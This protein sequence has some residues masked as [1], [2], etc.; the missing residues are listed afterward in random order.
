MS[1]GFSHVSNFTEYMAKVLRFVDSSGSGLR[2][3]DLP[4]GNGLLAEELRAR[5]HR[6]VCADINRENPDYVYA[7]FNER[8][9]FADGEFDAVAC[10][11]GIEHTLNAV[12]FIGEL[13]RIT[14]SGGRILLSTPN[15]QCAYSRFQFLCMG[16]FHQFTPDI[17]HH[18]APGELLDHGHI[19]PLSYLQLRYFF[20]H[21]GAKLIAVDSDRWKK[22]WLIPFLLPFFAVGR[23]WAQRK[24]VLD[25]ER[26]GE[27]REMVR[28]LF[29]P[30]VLFG[31]SLILMFEKK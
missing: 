5:G 23:I 2:V 27:F 24:V 16:V 13:C 15:L 30:P 26:R 28:H 4:A 12:D 19:S 10:T 14:R 3:L 6:V 18:R 11:E 9:P 31:R 25:G 29:S 22:K 20:E 21:Y 1:K 7:N 8:L 17:A